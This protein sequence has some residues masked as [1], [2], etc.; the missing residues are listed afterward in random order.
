M[1]QPRF[2]RYNDGTFDRLRGRVVDLAA[3][4]V[5]TPL[6]ID[7]TGF[8][9]VP[10]A[11]T[12]LEDFDVVAEFGDPNYVYRS[13]DTVNTRCGLT[14]LKLKINNTD[15]AQHTF[16]VTKDYTAFSLANKRFCFRYYIDPLLAAK[17]EDKTVMSSA[18]NLYLWFYPDRVGAPAKF[19]EVA[20][21]QGVGWHTV[22]WTTGYMTL[23]GGMVNSDFATCDRIIFKGQAPKSTVTADENYITFDMLEISPTGAT[24]G[25]VIFSFDDGRATSYTVGIK[26]LARY[27]FRS[28]WYIAPEVIGT[29]T[30][31]TWDQVKEAQDAGALICLHYL[32]TGPITSVAALRAF[33]R[34]QKNLLLDHGFTDGA[35]YWAIPGGSSSWINTY[36]TPAQF[37]ETTAEFFVN[38]RGTV[39]FWQ[40]GGTDATKWIQ[41]GIQGPMCRHPRDTRW[42]H[43]ANRANVL[44]TWKADIDKIVLEN[45]L[46]V[47]MFYM[48][49]LPTTNEIDVADFK[50]VVEYVKDLIDGSSPLE[51]ITLKDIVLGR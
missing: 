13:L 25:G 29:S 6:N 41:P 26:Y 44:A 38:T 34:K 7:T 15:T 48:H 19:A 45:N 39:A 49:G 5:L 14:S 42:S 2:D 33:Y 17:W 23:N 8:D 22:E 28:M 21:P 12:T 47:Q 24:K 11:E 51:V 36:L 20:L 37:Y 35:D 10:A 30:F 46:D 31:A 32:D 50:R 27:G 1:V 4:K 16:S 43:A 40:C 3:S 18:A 9:S